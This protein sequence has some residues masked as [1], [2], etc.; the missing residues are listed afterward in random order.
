MSDSVGAVRMRP[1]VSGSPDSATAGRRRG[2]VETVAVG[3]GV[4]LA[5]GIAF[6][7][8]ALVRAVGGGGV[9]WQALIGGLLAVVGAVN[10][11]QPEIGGLIVP[12]ALVVLLLVSGFFSISETSMMALNRYRLRHLVARK[13]RGARVAAELLARTDRFLG[14]V[15]LGNNVINAAVALMMAVGRA[16]AEDTNEGDLTDFLRNP[17][18]A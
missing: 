9:G 16:M 2:L 14:V 10:L 18:I 5:L 17:L 8:I 4:A 7:F 3:C 6:L 15:L 1:D 13:H 12:I 11:I